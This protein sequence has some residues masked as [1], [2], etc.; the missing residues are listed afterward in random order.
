MSGRITTLHFMKSIRETKT[1]EREGRRP[2]VSI[3]CITYN[4]REYI[5]DA[6]EGFLNQKCN[7]P[8][9]II[10]HDDASTDG[11]A[12]ILKGY[13]TEAYSNITVILQQENQ[14]SGGSR[15][16]LN[17]VLPLAKGKYIALCEGDDYWTDPY[18]IV[19]QVNFLEEN[20]D[21]GL[22][23]SR[24][25]VISCQ[26]TGRQYLEHNPKRF[27]HGDISFIDMLEF[28]PVN[29]PTVCIR[30]EI[31]QRLAREAVEGNKWFAID[32]WF[33]L[34]T[35]LDTRVFIAN[36]VMAVYRMHSSGISKKENFFEDRK[37]LI[38]HDVL[39]A[40]L[41]RYSSRRDVGK[42]LTPVARRITDVFLSGAIKFHSKLNL[43]FRICKYSGLFA[44][45]V[46]AMAR[47]VFSLNHVVLSFCF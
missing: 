21:Y 4:H 1:A 10:I 31:M 40:Y 7:F 47:R 34:M 29:T 11:T 13:N 3:C 26:E 12:E 46:S 36:E 41:G 43:A 16:L 17:F 27:S 9:E 45:T 30:A 6:I 35:A 39:I 23:A 8:V 32:K 14:Y 37:P 44:E 15:P 19:K 25:E 38:L 22:T 28:N 2:M 18:K 20:P 24:V 5:K 33:W 42:S